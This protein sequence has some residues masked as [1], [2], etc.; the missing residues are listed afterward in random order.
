MGMSFSVSSYRWVFCR[1]NKTKSSHGKGH[2]RLGA[3]DA[4]RSAREWE[5]HFLS[6][7]SS[8]SIEALDSCLSGPS[9]SSRDII[10]S[11]LRN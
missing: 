11:G 6:E 1:Y 8:Q 4:H 3:S 5:K 2:K 7:T 9:S 10:Y